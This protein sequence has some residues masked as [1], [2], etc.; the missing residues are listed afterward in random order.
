M[1][2]TAIKPEQKKQKKKNHEL[3]TFKTA[4]CISSSFCLA[5][6]IF[7]ETPAASSDGQ[8]RRPSLLSSSSEAKTLSQVLFPF[9]P[10]LPLSLKPSFLKTLSVLS[11][12]RNNQKASMED[13]RCRI[14]RTASSKAPAPAFRSINRIVRWGLLFLPLI[15]FLF[16]CFWFYSDP[17][18]ILWTSKLDDGL[19]T[20]HRSAPSIES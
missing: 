2:K 9:P 15:C 18:L 13:V 16:S 3:V 6:T 19:C 7:Y 8:I 17:F 11:S 4:I 14:G 12:L 20:W 10:F 5:R 1:L